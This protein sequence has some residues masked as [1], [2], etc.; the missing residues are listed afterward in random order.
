VRRKRNQGGALTGG[1]GWS[2]AQGEEA[3]AAMSELGW[4]AGWA[5]ARMLGWWRHRAEG[6]GRRVGA[7]ARLC[8]SVCG[9]GCA[10]QGERLVWAR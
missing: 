8:S 7:G 3:W 10:G 2:A 9:V 1:V 4:R 5:G 6:R